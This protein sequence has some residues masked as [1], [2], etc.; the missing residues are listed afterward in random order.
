MDEEVGSLQPWQIYSALYLG[1]YVVSAYFDHFV[2]RKD[3]TN[4]FNAYLAWGGGSGR[5]TLL[6]SILFKILH[7][8]PNS[9][10][11]TLFL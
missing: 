1:F 7:N 6:Q 5:I 2:I 4:Y 11:V 3:V 10:Y 9:N 8:T